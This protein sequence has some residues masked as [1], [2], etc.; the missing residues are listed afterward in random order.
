MSIISIIGCGN[1]GK[2]IIKSALNNGVK[3][4][5][6][7]A[8]IFNKNK[9]GNIRN[10]LNIKSIYDYTQNRRVIK[11]SNYIFLCVKPFDIKRTLL[12]IKGHISP[13]QTV[14]STAAGVDINYIRNIINR[15]NII[16]LMPNIGIAYNKGVVGVYS[17]NVKHKQLSLLCNKLFRGSKII[18]VDNEKSIDIMT[19]LSGCGPAFI[20]FFAEKMYQQGLKY[21]LSKSVCR[22]IITS[23]LITSS[24]LFN[25]L[26]YDEII[27]QIASKGGATQAGLDFLIKNKV[28]EIYMRTLDNSYNR[29]NNINKGLD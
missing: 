22:E 21:G 12:D 25:N 10:D 24:S 23:T 4:E 15:K 13:N 28:D 29:I 27:Y 18:Y 8:T 14:I 11:N 16:R 3:K 6:I 2:A 17:D 5:C 20:S 1:L 26:K 19:V 7:N 9:L